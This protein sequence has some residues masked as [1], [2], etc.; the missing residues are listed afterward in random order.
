MDTAID[1]LEALNLHGNLSRYNGISITKGN[2][3][4]IAYHLSGKL[5]V[6]FKFYKKTTI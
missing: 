2:T 1:L 4:G 3:M 5:C 6:T